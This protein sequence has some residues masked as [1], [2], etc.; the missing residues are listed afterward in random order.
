[1]FSDICQASVGSV[2]QFVFFEVVIGLEPFFFEFSPKGFCQ[3]QLRGV[4]R[5]EENKKPS[6]L[7]KLHAFTDD[8][9]S[10]H[11]CAV[12]DDKRLFADLKGELLQLL[13]D[14]TSVDVLLG[15]SPMALVVAA[16]QAKTVDLVPF[17]RRDADFFAGEL[18]AVRNVPFRANMAFISVKKVYQPCFG[19]FFEFSE[20]VY[21]EPVEFGVG[22]SLA[23]APDSL[24]FSAKAFKKRRKVSLLTVLSA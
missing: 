12:K 1:M 14:K 10:V 5:Q 7:P 8:F 2:E 13:A 11:P 20:A 15:C 3:V 4:R 9:R 18:P 17:F 24:V 22:L 16:Y 6:L 19:Q 21:F 23:T